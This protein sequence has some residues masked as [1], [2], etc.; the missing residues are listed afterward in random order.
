[1]DYWMMW[2]IAGAVCVGLELFVPG[3]VLIFFGLGCVCTA[4]VSLI[5][6]VNNRVWLQIALFLVFS[7]LSLVFL[8]KRFTLIFKGTM[9]YPEKKQ[10]KHIFEFADVLEPVS[11]TREGRIKYNGTTWNAVSLSGDIEAGA[12][13]RVLRREGITYVVEK[14]L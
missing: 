12:R 1:M 9:F 11:D 8:R 6:F 3:L 14:V 7:I 5:S 4:G 10:D 2:L 13:V